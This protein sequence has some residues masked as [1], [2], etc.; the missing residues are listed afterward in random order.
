MSITRKIRIKSH[1]PGFHETTRPSQPRA[2]TAV[3]PLRG[4]LLALSSAY[5]SPDP[6]L[7]ETGR[8]S[9]CY[10][11]NQRTHGPG[12]GSSR[13]MASALVHFTRPSTNLLL[14]WVVRKWDCPC[15]FVNTP[16]ISWRMLFS[17]EGPTRE[18][19][20]DSSANSLQ[21]IQFCY[22]NSCW[23]DILHGLTWIRRPIPTSILGPIKKDQIYLRAAESVTISIW[24]SEQRNEEYYSENISP[25]NEQTSPY[26]PRN[27]GSV[28][29]T[30]QHLASSDLR[31][32]RLE[33]H[34]DNERQQN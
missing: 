13:C 3:R 14:R 5:H 4:D 33:H 20:L 18:G 23:D 28:T 31:V 11:T 15:A 24:L 25:S 27:H 8:N 30:Q 19:L 22:N 17:C 1:T 34:R 7:S 12:R 21:P 6:S 16:D 10:P 2:L 9:E 29:Q 32:S 26:T